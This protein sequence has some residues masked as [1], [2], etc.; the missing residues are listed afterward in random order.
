MSNKLKDEFERIH[1][2]ETTNE[3]EDSIGSIAKRIINENDQGAEETFEREL[4]ELIASVKSSKGIGDKRTAYKAFFCLNVFYR[5]KK[6]QKKLE[7]LITDYKDD[8]SSFKT[9]T[10]LRLLHNLMSQRDLEKSIQESYRQTTQEAFSNNAGCWHLFAEI[11]VTHYEKTELKNTDDLWLGR[12]EMAIEK[13]IK[14]KDTYAKFYSTKARL[15]SI[16]KQYPIALSAIADAIRLE[17]DSNAFII[18]YYEYIRV[19]IVYKRLE[20]YQHELESKTEESQKRLESK[21]E[22]SLKQLENKISERLH[23]EALQNYTVIS[24]FIGII[25]IIIATVN[26]TVKMNAIQAI[27]VLMAFLGLLLC[28]FYC[29]G[30][31]IHGKGLIYEKG[32]N[33]PKKRPTISYVPLIIGVSLIVA[34]ILICIFILPNWWN[35]GIYLKN[36][37][38]YVLET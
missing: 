38:H 22:E 29:L 37:L 25:S 14:L 26:V 6:R 27:T 34:A 23:G 20:K 24:F 30:F 36:T 5:Y 17:D 4:K 8:F 28:A 2:D 32:S 11:V 15:L 1:A 31:I 18:N 3:Y 21:T 33:E 19:Q 9:Y 12:A 35:Y 13:A 10:H 16:K 7:D